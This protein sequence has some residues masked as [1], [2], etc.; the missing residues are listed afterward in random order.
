[1][2]APAVLASELL[3]ERGSAVVSARVRSNPMGEWPHAKHLLVRT[4]DGESLAVSDTGSPTAV[5]TVVFLHGRRG[6]GPS[7]Q[8]YRVSLY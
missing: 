7:R 2:T 8:V 5:H 6:V 4:S 3:V 1:M